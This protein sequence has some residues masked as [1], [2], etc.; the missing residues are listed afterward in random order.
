VV[1]GPDPKLYL[2]DAIFIAYA[3]QDIP[4]LLEIARLAK[5]LVEAEVFSLGNQP[6]L[7]RSLD[8]ALTDLEKGE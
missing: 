3:H 1:T 5:A 2:S 8:L 4:A 7:V 6:Q